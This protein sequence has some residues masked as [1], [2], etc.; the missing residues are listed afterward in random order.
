MR[1]RL[2]FVVNVD[3]FFLSHRLPIALEA[4][5]Q[6]YEVHLAV[7]LTDRLAELEAH[8]LTV[9]PLPLDR[10]STGLSRE[11]RT[12]VEV[13]RVMRRVRPDLVHLVTIKPV[14]FG[15]IAARLVG[16]PGVVAAISGLGSTAVDAGARAAVFRR[17]TGWLYRLALGKRNLAVIFQNAEDRDYLVRA[18]A[19]DERKI[20]MIR[21]SGV[22]LQDYRGDAAKPQDPPVVVMAARLL[23]YKGVED[24]VA[25]AEL[26]RK[27]GVGARFQLAGAPDPHS[28]NSIEPARLDEWRRGG[29]VEVLGHRDDV[30]RLFAQAGI[31]VLPSYYGEGLPKV[32]MEAAACA[33]AVVTT[34]HPGCREAIEPGVTGLLVPPRSPDRL[35][36]AIASLLNDPP[37]MLGMGRAGRALAEREFSIERIVAA[38]MAIY[39]AL[40]PGPGIG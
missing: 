1:K 4:M 21:G 6:G 3:W 24:Y 33:C 18:A 14:I 15:G 29:A 39:E 20:R 12:F 8:G 22:D 31:V 35:A 34:D 9:H 13:L 10:S 36:Q 32:L 2:L 38:H 16:V 11:L 28:R 37:R 19:L 23:R 17:V 5:R 7:G 40:L 26:L 27:E 30:A 25:A